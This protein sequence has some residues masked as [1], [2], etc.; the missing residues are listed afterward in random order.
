MKRPFPNLAKFGGCLALISAIPCLFIALF[1]FVENWRGARA[2]SDYQNQLKAEGEIIDLRTLV[3][4]GKP[5]DDL[6]KSPLFA[7]YYLKPQPDP[8]RLANIDIYFDEKKTDKLLRVPDY[9]KENSTDLVPWQTFYRGLPKAKLAA[10]ITS[11]ARDILTVLQPFEDEMKQVD[12][13]VSRPGA[14]FPTDYE[15]PASTPA[16]SSTAL[17]FPCKFLDLHG[18]ALLADNQTESAKADYLA[19][20]RLCQPLA[21]RCNMIDYLVLIAIRLID[22][23]ILWEGLHRHS[24][25]DAQL[26]EFESTLAAFDFLEYAIK[27]LRVERAYDLGTMRYA[28]NGHVDQLT[29]LSPS[30]SLYENF[31]SFELLAFLKLRP[32]GWV[33]REY[34]FLSAKIQNQIESIH[35]QSGIL[36]PTFYKNWDDYKSQDNFWKIQHVASGVLLVTQ[37]RFGPYVAKAETYRRLARIACRL[38]QFRIAHGKYPDT[39]DQIPGLPAHLNQEVLSDAPLRY[40]RKAETYQLYSIGWNQ[41]DDNATT[42]KEPDQADWPWQSP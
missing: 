20:F 12:I 26:R 18:I 31:G 35:L 38:E 11:P 4:P 36:D 41:I 29:G 14:F 16:G 27:S 39:L 42:S 8:T 24:W 37:Q 1:Y 7:D 10:A 21:Q 6:S 3:P 19:S 17:L 34:L 15:L 28:F 33:D 9:R 22:D 23:T 13:T 30:E 40:Q 5:E 32:S 2:W 25:N